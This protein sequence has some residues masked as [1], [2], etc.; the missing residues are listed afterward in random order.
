MKKEGINL[1]NMPRK[2]IF[3]MKETVVNERRLALD[4]LLATLLEIPGHPDVRRFLSLDREV[5]TILMYSQVMIG[6]L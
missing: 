6:C 5:T 4:N 2:H 1:P 3:N